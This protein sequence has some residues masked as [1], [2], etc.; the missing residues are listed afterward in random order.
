MTEAPTSREPLRLTL[1]RTVSIALFAG[2]V[3]ALWTG[4]IARWPVLTLLL[5]WPALGGHWVDLLFLNGVR[6]R[7]PRNPVVR[8]VARLV[9]WFIGG[10]LLAVGV[11]VT[12]W[13]LL[14]RPRMALLPW[15]TAGAAFIAI[16]LVAHAVLQ[17]RGRPSFYNGLG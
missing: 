10:M 16:E 11:R 7:L 1:L 12:A 4:R 8:R 5:L 6:S 13:M 9:V 17:A 3:A 15:V 14:D 2:A